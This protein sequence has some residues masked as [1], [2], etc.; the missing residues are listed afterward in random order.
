MVNGRKRGNA[1][2]RDIV[3]RWVEWWQDRFE[4]RS[5][6]LAGSDIICPGW[7]PWEP[8]VKHR[9]VAKLLW[10]FRPTKALLDWWNQTTENAMKSGKVP[11]LVFKAQ[12][13]W[14]AARRQ[15]DQ[16][17]SG[18]PIILGSDE[19]VVSTLDHFERVN[20]HRKPA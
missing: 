2:E 5:M 9:K 3:S 19:V 20:K 14:L 13:I 7:F 16:L 12:G 6:G 1:G 10:L 15:I 18:L 11:L 17:D 4:R 8:E